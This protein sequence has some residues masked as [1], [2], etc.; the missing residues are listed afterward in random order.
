[1]SEPRVLPQALTST[2]MAAS[3][4]VSDRKVRRSGYR[5]S[6][7]SGLAGLSIGSARLRVLT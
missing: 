3:R 7:S 6:A 1:V 2:A 5:A 4:A